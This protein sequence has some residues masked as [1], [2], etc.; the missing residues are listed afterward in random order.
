M[1]G[2]AHRA[3]LLD[4]DL[5]FV[6]KVRETLRHAGYETRTTADGATLWRT[7]TDAPAG[8]MDAALLQ[9][10]GLPPLVRL[11][12]PDAPLALAAD[13]PFRW[14]DEGKRGTAVYSR[15]LA[16]PVSPAQALPLR[17][18]EAG[19]EGGRSG[20]SAKTPD[21]FWRVRQRTLSADGQRLFTVATG[22]AVRGERG[23]A[24][25]LY[26]LEARSQPG[27]PGG[28]SGVKR[29]ARVA[30]PEAALTFPFA[31]TADLTWAAASDFPVGLVLISLLDRMRRPLAVGAVRPDALLAVSP[32]AGRVAI[33]R[34][35]HL[36]LWDA[37]D[38]WR[39]QEWDFAAEVTSI[40]FAAGFG[41]PMLGVGLA[42]GLA[43]LLG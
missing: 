8:L 27:V 43:V 7:A 30:E 28:R 37:R 17:V 18:S 3:L 23:V 1:P 15:P 40:C 34:A 5:F 11:A 29:V 32:D 33:A 9:Q 41:E 42:N 22:G 10:P 2:E 38:G 6:A 26:D 4:N 16:G 13:D 12:V 20:A 31:A 36:D 14:A 35:A 39:V 21:Q 25:S 19:R 24:L